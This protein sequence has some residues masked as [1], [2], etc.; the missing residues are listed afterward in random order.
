MRMPYEQADVLEKPYSRL[1]R[2]TVNTFTSSPY[3]GVPGV[4]R[5]GT[6]KVQS[7]ACANAGGGDAAL[8]RLVEKQWF[9]GGNAM[10]VRYAIC[11]VLVV[12]T[13]Q[14]KVKPPVKP[15]IGNALHP[16]AVHRQ[17]CRFTTKHSRGSHAAHAGAAVLCDR[18][19]NAAVVDV[20]A[21][22]SRG[23][24]RAPDA[25]TRERG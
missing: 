4:S 13:A 12:V 10:L 5:P 21:T 16:V 3:R 11:Q 24:V 15:L 20:C 19:N 8:R 6:R 9:A 7:K 18:G 1:R 14:D 17:S 25:W 22:A 23:I 2:D